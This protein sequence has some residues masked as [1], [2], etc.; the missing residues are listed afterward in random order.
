MGIRRGSGALVTQLRS[1]L[2]A[3]AYTSGQFLPT[4]RELGSR[5]G[6]SPEA[7]RRALKSLEGEG[8]VLAEPR[9]GFRVT[10][11]PSKASDHCPV[12]YVT[13]FAS[14]LSNS[15]PVNWAL[16]RALGGASAKRGWSSLGIHTGGEA[17][18]NVLEKLSAARAWG[19]ILDTRDNALYEVVRRTDL[20]VV[21]VNS[22][23]EEGAIDVVI[24]DNYRGGFLAARHLIDLGAKKIAWVGAVEQF[25]HSRERMAGASAGLAA[26]GRSFAPD[27]VVNAFAAESGP[28]LRKLLTRSNPPDG[29]LAFG[30]GIH[31]KITAV[32]KEL[33][34]VIGKDVKVVGWSVEEAYETGFKATYSGHRIPPAVVWSA[35][36]M[37]DVALDR[38]NQ[39]RG[40]PEAVRLR[41]CI[42]TRIRIEK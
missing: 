18:G 6:V 13:E 14:D 29:L 17:S 22:W 42:P 36:S 34:L 5:Y 7:V 25:C 37:A 8:L 3:G 23:V 10:T 16:N 33:G 39:R 32:T 20:P 41:T 26:S 30:E 19:V 28:A 27:V 40:N 12:A 4:V 38:L 35:S 1:S 11:E 9:Q 15:Q 2:E 21:M 31:R 24:Q